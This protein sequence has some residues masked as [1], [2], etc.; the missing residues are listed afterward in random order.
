MPENGQ[1][2]LPKALYVD[3]NALIAVP[4]T[5]ATQSIAELVDL[6][7]TLSMDGAACWIR[8]P[9]GVET[10]ANAN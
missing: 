2:I 4:N 1:V 5:L 9:P 3:T 7:G 8:L 6:A 10:C